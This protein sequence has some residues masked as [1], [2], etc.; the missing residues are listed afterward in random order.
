MYGNAPYIWSNL[1]VMQT[2]FQNNLPE[3]KKIQNR[4]SISVFLSNNFLFQ[5]YH[6]PKH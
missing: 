5:K 3:W 4:F 2:L 6:S 1:Y